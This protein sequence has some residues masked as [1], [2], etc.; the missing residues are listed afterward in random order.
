MESTA[1]KEKFELI[2][3]MKR[4]GEWPL[5]WISSLELVKE[6]SNLG[7][8]LVGC[9]IGVCYGWNLVYML[10]NISVSKIYAIDPYVPYLDG[11]AGY[12]N[13]ETLQYMK[14]HFKK[15]TESFS[16]IEFLEMKS[17]DAHRLIEDHSL[18]FIFI[19]G[20]HSYD[21][22]LKDLKN[23]FPKVKKGGIFAGHDFD[24]D[25]DN[26]R[27]VK[28]ALEGFFAGTEKLHFCKNDCWYIKKF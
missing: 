13:T 11:P 21:Q 24:F 23:Y 17:D 12:V 14:S 8:N 18:D 16:S 22:V 10:E 2:E 1:I 3:V 27:P 9:E 20:D 28:R 25:H 7:K 6:F 5:W 4:R 26:N 15:N 19:D